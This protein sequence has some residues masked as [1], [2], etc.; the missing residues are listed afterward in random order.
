M[1]VR[2]PY[3]FILLKRVVREIPRAVA[4]FTFVALG[5][6]Q[7]IDNR[8]FFTIRDGLIQRNFPMVGVISKIWSFADF[9]ILSVPPENR[10]LPG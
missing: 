4:V 9:G 5:I 2:I 1:I 10:P 3:F 6:F 7:G 8:R